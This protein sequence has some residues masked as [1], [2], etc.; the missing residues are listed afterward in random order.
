MRSLHVITS[1]ARRGAETF[2]VALC[3]ALESEDH[4]VRIVALAASGDPRSLDVPLLGPS[5]GSRQTL[6]ALRTAARSADVVVAH[7]SATLNACALA[8]AGGRVPFV[9][10]NIGDPSYWAVAGWRRQRVG[11]M[12]RR[13]ARVTALWPT[14]ATEIATMHHIPI[15]RIDV[16]PNAV[17]EE[18]FPRATTEER[19]Q[20]RAS[21]GLPID[22]PCLAIV[23]ALSP[24]KDVAAAIEVAAA[25]P[26]ATLLIAGAGELEAQLRELAEALAPG[27]VRFL[28][29]V[30]D[31][32]RVYAAADLLLLPSRSE[33]MP[34]VLVEAGL[35]GTPTVATAVGA[36]PDMIEDGVT[37]FLTGPPEHARFVA[38][39][40]DALPRA[41]EIG[42]AAATAFRGRY[43]MQ[44]VAALWGSTLGRATTPR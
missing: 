35:V 16:V 18:R 32:R 1:D 5:R 38:H 29:Q 24:E 39:V 8:L 41:A 25:T 15:E 13:A 14:A 26:R 4:Q 44:S 30:D 42:L 2:A 6:V 12:L 20:I 11:V 28:G 9:Y 3:A 22:E 19:Q 37:G 17:T 23:G 27:R 43:S 33:G 10:R 36:V 7:G 21:L 31:P 40:I 34:A